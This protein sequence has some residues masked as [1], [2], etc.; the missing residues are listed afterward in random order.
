MRAQQEPVLPLPHFHPAQ[1]HLHEHNST[2][3]SAEGS[4]LI[5]CHP[6]SAY[7]CA[8][9]CTAHSRRQ[10][11]LDSNPPKF[12]DGLNLKSLTL[13]LNAVVSNTRTGYID[14]QLK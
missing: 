9:L 3:P 12:S 14:L 7:T 13:P 2:L 11:L 4:A 10:T 5:S 1:M 6:P 8:C